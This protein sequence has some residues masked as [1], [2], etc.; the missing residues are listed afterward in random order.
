MIRNTAGLRSGQSRQRD[1]F[2]VVDRVY[3]NPTFT[4]PYRPGAQE[5]AAAMG[6]ARRRPVIPLGDAMTR[7]DIVPQNT[8]LIQNDPAPRALTPMERLLTT[9]NCGWFM[10]DRRNDV[11]RR[12]GITEGLSIVDQHLPASIRAEAQALARRRRAE[13]AFSEAR[14][15]YAVLLRNE[16]NGLRVLSGDKEACL[17]D[18][19]TTNRARAKAATKH[20]RAM[21][22][23]LQFE[24]TREVL[25]DD[26]PDENQAEAMR[27]IETVLSNLP[28]RNVD[29]EE[30][31]F[32]NVRVGLRNLAMATEDSVEAANDFLGDDFTGGS[33]KLEKDL[34]NVIEDCVHMFDDEED[35]KHAQI[36]MSL[37]S[38]PK[39]DVSDDEPDDDED[40]GG[41]LDKEKEILVVVEK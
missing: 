10:H 32:E 13:E 39:R 1:E 11:L 14:F 19:A 30:D 25:E 41:E 20:E 5:R 36:E 33:S 6:V 9:F 3:G 21:N 4:R 24:N 27:K 28:V 7:Y 18:L 40:G 12:V 38:A 22:F 15:A 31:R 29:R 26:V 35:A 2:A 37:P 8:G 17:A 16:R 34:E 23:R